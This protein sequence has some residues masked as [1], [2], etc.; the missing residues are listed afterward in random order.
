MLEAVSRIDGVWGMEKML[1]KKSHKIKWGKNQD[2][3]MILLLQAQ[4]LCTVVP[5][6]TSEIE[7]WVE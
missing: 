6:E 4:L 5:N 7:F 3:K 1:E 2:I